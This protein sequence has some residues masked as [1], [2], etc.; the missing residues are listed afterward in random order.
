MSSYQLADPVQV[1][2]PRYPCDLNISGAAEEIIPNIYWANAVPDSNGTVNLS[3]GGEPL[4][5]EGLGYHDKKWGVKPLNQTLDTW[6]WGHARL[7]PY[8]FVW[9]DAL[10]KGGKEYV[11]SWIS[12]NGTTMF[13]SCENGSVV[14]RPWGKDCAYPPS[15]RNQ[16]RLATI[17]ATTVEM[18]G[19]SL[20]VSLPVPSICLLILI[21]GSWGL[22]QVVSKAW[23]SM[24]GRPYASRSKISNRMQCGYEKLDTDTEIKKRY[25]NTIS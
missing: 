2:P 12:Y 20:L 15:L 17:S 4:R 7:G 18:G 5:F 23:I 22:F 16:L 13:Q 9:F 14:V 11:S 25:S 24:R 1:S 19:L 6:Y 10:T 8:S 3:I 21:S